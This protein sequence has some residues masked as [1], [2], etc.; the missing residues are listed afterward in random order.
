MHKFSFDSNTFH[1]HNYP[2]GLESKEIIFEDAP[3]RS[4]WSV[5]V[6]R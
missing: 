3:K 4:L 5:H 2:I 1:F 6:C